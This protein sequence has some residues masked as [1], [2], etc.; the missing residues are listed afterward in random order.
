MVS[1]AQLERIN[2]GSS[3]G[4]F[5]VTCVAAPF[6]AFVRM[7]ASASIQLL[8]FWGRCWQNQEGDSEAVL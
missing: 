5:A 8:S 4:A 7:E 3:Q 2:P 6:E 1:S